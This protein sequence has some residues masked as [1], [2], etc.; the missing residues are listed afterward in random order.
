MEQL[1]DLFFINDLKNKYPHEISA[2]QAQRV[3]V[4]RSIIHNPDLLLLD[5][6]FANLDQNLKEKVQVNLKEILK[7]TEITSIIVTHDKYEAFYL[8]D[9]C[10]ILHNKKM[11]QFDRPYNIHHKPNSK[12]VV[13]F[14]NRGVLIPAKVVG[15]NKL[16]NEE[17]G[18]IQGEFSRDYPLNEEVELLI[19]PEDLIHDDESDLKLEVVDKK[20][21]GTNFVY[22]LK[23]NSKTLLPVFVHSHH[24]HLHQ[25][26]EKFGIKK[27]IFIDHLVCF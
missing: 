22:T 1:L 4:V 18:E 6:P 13:D 23:T 8:A 17:L 19:Q 26:N 21:R 5:E 25:E 10:G 2:G 14:F 20:F 3:C 24:E 9:Y 27:P 15:K 7:E 16:F 11:V 12:E